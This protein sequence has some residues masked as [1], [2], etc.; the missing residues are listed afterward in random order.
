MISEGNKPS[1][2][3]GKFVDELPRYI[4]KS[5]ELSA[6]EE[7][8]QKAGYKASLENVVKWFWEN[9]SAVKYYQDK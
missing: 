7:A 8:Y 5:D 1:G 9:E 3:L 4:T 6:Y 2:L